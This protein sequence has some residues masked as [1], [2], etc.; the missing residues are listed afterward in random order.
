[1]G[2]HHVT[3]HNMGLCHYSKRQLALAA[4]CFDEA[5]ALNSSYQK[6]ATWLQRVNRE[7][8]IEPPAAVASAAGSPTGGNRARLASAESTSTFGSTSRPSTPS[9]AS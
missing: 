3:S 1:M 8:G 2:K 4:T 7:L 6:A 5:Y 9:S